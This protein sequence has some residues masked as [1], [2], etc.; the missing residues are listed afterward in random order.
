MSDKTKWAPNGEQREI[1]LALQEESKK[2]KTV[3][4]FARKFLPFGRSKFDQ[5]MDVFDANRPESYFDKVSADVREELMID[6]KNILDEI[7]LKRNQF[8]L[9]DE[10]EI[11]ITSKI[12]ALEQAVRECSAKPGPERLIINLGPTGAGKTYTCN[13]LIKKFSARFVEVRDIWRDSK[14]GYV[15]LM[16]IC[17]GLEIRGIR[18]GNNIAEIQDQ[19]IKYCLERKIVLCF[20]EGEHF[21]HASLNLL[22]LL[23]NKTRL[24]PVIFVVPSQYDKWF[25]WFRNEAE[26]IARRTHVIID[27]S[28]IEAKDAGLFFPKNQFEKP[29]EALKYICREANTFGHYSMLRRISKQLEG[30]AHAELGEKGDV[31]KAVAAARRQM[32]RETRK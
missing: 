24:V 10:S 9:V 19:L 13:H 23:L 8:S 11:I 15:P 17:R 16:D 20:D 3:V 30:I 28:I 32:I 21:G 14:T 18:N 29:A 25:G 12:T 2:E 5:I 7:P 31:V 1:L 27:S 4:E 22:K 6:L 26:Q